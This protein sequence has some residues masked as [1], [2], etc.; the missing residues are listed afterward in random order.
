MTGSIVSYLGIASYSVRALNTND[1]I[2]QLSVTQQ[3]AERGRCYLTL[4]LTTFIFFMIVQILIGR[5]NLVLQNFQALFNVKITQIQ[6]ITKVTLHC[7]GI[8]IKSS[9]KQQRK[10]TG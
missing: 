2:I 9:K 10:L 8:L 4:K 7:I 1:S 6:Y 3:T 5:E